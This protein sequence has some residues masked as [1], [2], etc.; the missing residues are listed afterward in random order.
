MGKGDK[1]SKRGKIIMGSYGKTRPKHKKL[2]LKT[3]EKQP[4]KVEKEIVE[5]KIKPEIP[6][7]EPIVQKEIQTEPIVQEEIQTEAIVQEVVPAAEPVLAE[8]AGEEPKVAAK[9]APKDKK[10][11]TE[12]KEKKP[13]VKKEPKAKK[14]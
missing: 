5:K 6:K 9:K 7:A 2:S 14:E 10:E 3:V 4:K 8:T 13:A 12:T 1:K 11:A